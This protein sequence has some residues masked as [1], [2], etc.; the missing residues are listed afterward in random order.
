MQTIWHHAVQF[1]L[2][3]TCKHS[4]YHLVYLSHPQLHYCCFTHT[5]H[6]V[7]ALK[8]KQ[9][10]LVGNRRHANHGSFDWRSYLIIQPSG[11]LG[12]K[13]IHAPHCTICVSNCCSFKL[14]IKNWKMKTYCL[15]CWRIKKKKENLEDKR[16]FFWPCNV[17]IFPS[18]NQNPFLFRFTFTLWNI[19]L[20]SWDEEEGTSFSS[21]ALC[22]YIK[23]GVS[24]K[25]HS[26]LLFILHERYRKPGLEK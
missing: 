4:L 21:V 16:Q 22:A 7:R 1:D 13:S 24:S 17:N 8:T 9:M 23:R 6:C 10:E 18:L 3:Q 2:D 14:I 15:L 19:I 25:P 12:Y 5:S 11:R 20:Q 26:D